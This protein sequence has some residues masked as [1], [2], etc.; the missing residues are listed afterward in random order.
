[1][2]AF[3]YTKGRGNPYVLAWVHKL[4]TAGKSDPKA[5]FLQLFKAKQFRIHWNTLDN[6]RK[7]KNQLK[8]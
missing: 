1:M 2:E 5:S 4:E 6:Q 7:W 3:Q 8:M